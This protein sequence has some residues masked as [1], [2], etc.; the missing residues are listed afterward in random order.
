MARPRKDKQ[1]RDATQQL[2]DEQNLFRAIKVH[3]KV[4]P[5]K[6]TQKEIEAVFRAYADIMYTCTKENIRVNLPYIGEFYKQRMRGFRGGYVNI[7]D[8]PFKKGTT[9]HMEYRPPKPDHFLLQFD[10]RN[11]IKVKFKKETSDN[12]E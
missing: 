5:Y 2:L 1:E 3:S 6:L 7:A 12:N 11:A 9:H 8:E 10:L 4:K